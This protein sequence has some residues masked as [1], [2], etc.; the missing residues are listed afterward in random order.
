MPR[1]LGKLP[2]RRDSRTL[3]LRDYIQRN[4]PDPPAA[5]HWETGISDWGVMGNN[6]HGNCVIVTAAHMRL[7][8]RMNELDDSRRIS[9]REVIELSRTMGALNGYVILDRLKWWRKKGM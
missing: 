6:T 2:A 7:T 4:F 1:L 9:D 3:N 5:R 8:W